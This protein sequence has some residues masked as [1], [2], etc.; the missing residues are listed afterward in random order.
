MI[1]TE[2]TQ[3]EVIYF[4]ALIE[5]AG[6]T[7]AFVQPGQ[8]PDPLRLVQEALQFKTESNV[9]VWVVLDSEIPG[10]DPV[11][12]RH[13]KKAIATARRFGIHFAIASPFFEAW[14]LAHFDGSKNY[15]I[16]KEN[17]FLRTY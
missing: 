7:N 16:N 2:G 1:L 15:N 13:L 6:K 10:H 11:R 4:K 9:E 3:T 5:Y 8:S 12:D 14:L 17:R